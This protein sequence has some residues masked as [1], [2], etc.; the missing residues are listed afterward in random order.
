MAEIRSKGYITAVQEEAVYGAG[1]DRTV[2]DA[3]AARTVASPVALTGTV[4]EST[5]LCVNDTTSTTL[6]LDTDYTV[7]V[8]AGITTVT[9]IAGT[10]FTDSDLVTITYGV[11]ADADVIL[12][13]TG[14]YMTTDITALE[15]D[16]ANGSFFNCP[17][18][19]GT[20]TTAGTITSDVLVKTDG[21]LNNHYLI[22]SG[23]GAYTVAGANKFASSQYT[24]ATPKADVDIAVYGAL[25]EADIKVYKGTDSTGTLMTVTTDYTVT[26]VSGVITVSIVS[27]SVNWADGDSVFIASPNSYAVSE[28]A[29]GTGAGEL[30]KFSQPSDA[31]VSLVLRQYLGGT[32]TVVR[33][34]NGI[35]PNSITFNLTAGE[36]AKVDVDLGGTETEVASSGQNVLTKASCGDGAFSVKRAVIVQDGTVLSDASDVV[37]TC[38]NTVTDVNGVESDGISRRVVVGKSYMCSFTPLISSTTGNDN[39]A[40]FQQNSVISIY[41]ELENPQ[42]DKFALYLPNGRIT[43][44]GQTDDGGLAREPIEV[45]GFEDATGE[46]GYL[47]VEYRA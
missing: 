18:L 5:V 43:S 31:A 22:K 34:Y 37:F 6:V 46:A 44:L 21:K 7:T 2:T 23:M 11:W 33:D 12:T 25:S 8:A 9:F 47:Y 19:S 16:T 15:R 26:T 38:E 32:S 41:F 1:L 4:Q 35:I 17:S 36:L 40:K 28:V 39:L 24:L 45:G 13:D 10:N 3:S 29:T 27:T 30:Y 20:E 42:G 14:S